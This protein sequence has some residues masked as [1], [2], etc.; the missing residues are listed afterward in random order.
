MDTD[1]DAVTETDGQSASG[2]EPAAATEERSRRE[3]EFARRT[4]IRAGWA[5]PV[6]L[7]AGL[8]REA[9]AGVLLPYELHLDVGECDGLHGDTPPVC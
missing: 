8:P 6:V 9:R 7:A 3:A 1:R 5:V 4:L 2:A